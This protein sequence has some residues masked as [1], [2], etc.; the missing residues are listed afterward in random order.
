MHELEYMNS[1]VFIRVT[2]A[3]TVDIAHT[4]HHTYVQASVRSCVYAREEELQHIHCSS[5][6]N[7]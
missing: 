3:G 1:N 7:A 5:V 4:A 2:E 6:L